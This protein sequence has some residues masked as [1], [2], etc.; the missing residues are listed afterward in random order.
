MKTRIVAELFSPSLLPVAL[1]SKGHIKWANA[2]FESIPADIRSQLIKQE[3]VLVHDYLFERLS[4][5]ERELLIGTPFVSTQHERKLIRELLPALATGG[6]PWLT[7]ARVLGPMIGKSELVA[8]KHQ[9]EDADELLGHWYDGD[10]LPPRRLTSEHAIAEKVYAA[11]DD[12][13]LFANPAQEYP[14]DSLVAD[15]RPLYFASQRVDSNDKP[16][17]YLALLESGNIDALAENLRLLQLAGDVLAGHFASEPE[18]L[19]ESDDEQL[20]PRD[21]LTG[22]PGRSAFD[23]AL[24]KAE[25]RYLQTEKNCEMAMLDINGLSA[26]N[27]LKGIEYGDRVLKLLAKG[28]K[29]I[30]RSGDRVFRF[31]GDEFVLLMPFGKHAPPLIKRLKQVESQLRKDTG[32]ETFSLAYGISSLSETQGSSD[33]LMLLCDRRLRDSKAEQ[34]K[35]T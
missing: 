8:V 18:A 27:N 17:G 10:T 35:E 2:S 11:K 23:A 9:S 5:D 26:I 13:L 16:R 20:H 3:K 6:D 1:L 29:S 28:L 22:V 19:P 15:S 21:E 34:R 7:C 24:E 31:G 12:R 33:D 30:C 25:L 32:I 4:C 14:E